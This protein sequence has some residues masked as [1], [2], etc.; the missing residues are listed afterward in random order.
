MPAQSLRIQAEGGNRELDI[1][2]AAFPSNHIG[3]TTGQ[4]MKT[5]DVAASRLTMCSK[6]MGPRPACTLRCTPITHP[7]H[8]RV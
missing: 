4:N 8:R 1:S 3:L 5:S 7:V 2:E 6:Q